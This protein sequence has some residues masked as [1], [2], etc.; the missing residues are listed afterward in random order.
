MR[1]GPKYGECGTTT[2]PFA[3]PSAKILRISVTPPILVMLGC[4][5]PTAPT[6]KRRLNSMKFEM[7]SPAA[8]VG[9]IDRLFDPC[10]LHVGPFVR[11]RDRLVHGPWA[12]AI[13]HERHL[14]ATHLL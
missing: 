10:E 12:R 3:S 9:R 2:T 8:I 5:M 6:S 1:P 11:D 14:V 7:F 4:A 13:H